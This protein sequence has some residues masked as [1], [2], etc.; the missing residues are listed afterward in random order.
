MRR[1][2]GAAKP[3]APPPALSD[4]IAS[5]DSRA[6]SIDKKIAR[7]DAELRKYKD[8]M[9]KMREGPAKNAVKQKALRVLKQKKM[10]ENQSDNLR[11]QS[12]NMEQANFATETLKDT[13]ATVAAMKVGV[14]TM[15][16]E[17]KKIN[18]DQIDD[19]Q[20][21]LAD[22]LQ[23]A[24]EIQ[25][26]LG[27]SYA[28][29]DIDESE[30]E[31]EL[32]ALGDEIGLDA[33]SSYLDEIAAPNAPSREPG[34]ESVNAA[35]FGFQLALTMIMASFLQKLGVYYS[36]GRWLLCSTG[37]TRFL[38]PTDVELKT[39]MKAQT[40]E[41]SRRRHKEKEGEVKSS[42][43]V[44][45]N[46]DIPLETAKV[47]ST[48]VGQ[49]KFYTEY[50]W[51]LDFSLFSIF[52]YA[53]SEWYYYYFESSSTEINLSLL[54]CLLV[55]GFTLKILWSVTK[56]YFLGDE[57]MGER[58]MCIVA[59]CAYLVVAMAL[60]V[61]DEDTLE[62]GLDAA[63]ASF[64]VRAAV[65]M[66]ER[67]IE[68]DG[69]ASKL[70]LKFALA[71]KAAILGAFLTFPGFRLAQ[72]HWDALRKY[73][74]SSEEDSGIT[75]ARKV[76]FVGLLH[77]NYIAPLVV[78][79]AWVRP[80][81]RDYFTL[82]V[83]SGMS[84]PLMSEAA[85]ETGRLWLIVAV[86]LLR[87]VLMPFYLQAY[88]NLAYKRIAKQKKEAGKISN[89]D[90]QRGVA[91]VFYYLCV[92]TLQ[93]AAPMI[94]C[95]FQLF[96]LKSAG[97][98]SWSISDEL[99]CPADD[100]MAKAAF[101]SDEM[102]A[103]ESTF[104][105]LTKQMSLTLSSVR[106]VFSETVIR[107]V[108]S[109]TLWWTGF[110]WF[111]SSA[112]GEIRTKQGDDRQ[113]PIGFVLFMP[114]S[115][116]QEAYP[117]KIR[118]IMIEKNSENEWSFRAMSELENDLQQQ[119]EDLTRTSDR[120]VTAALSWLNFVIEDPE[121][122]DVLL[123]E[124]D[125]DEVTSGNLKLET[126]ADPAEVPLIH[127]ESSASEDGL[128]S[129]SEEESSIV[130]RHDGANPTN[131]ILNCDVEIFDSQLCN[132]MDSVPSI[133]SVTN[134]FPEDVF[135]SNAPV[136]N[137]SDEL[138]SVLGEVDVEQSSDECSA[139][140]EDDTLHEDMSLPSPS[141]V[142]ESSDAPFEN[143]DVPVPFEDLT[144]HSI[145]IFEGAGIIHNKSILKRS[146]SFWLKHSLNRCHVEL[147]D[148]MSLGRRFWSRGERFKRSKSNPSK[149][150]IV[151]AREEGRA[152]LDYEFKHRRNSRQ[153]RVTFNLN[154]GVKFIEKFGQKK[155]RDYHGH[156]MSDHRTGKPRTSSA[157]DRFSKRVEEDRG[158]RTRA[159]ARNEQFSAENP[160]RLCSAAP[161]TESFPR[162]IARRQLPNPFRNR[163]R[164][165]RPSPNECRKQ[166][167]H[168]L[169]S[170]RVSACSSKWRIK[171]GLSE[172]GAP[173][174]A[175]PLMETLSIIANVIMK[176]AA[177]GS[178]QGMPM[179]RRVPQ[180]FSDGIH[181]TSKAVKSPA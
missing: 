143:S 149:Y 138:D 146:S 42:F 76:L 124:D 81:A 30:L 174:D 99:E 85:F 63:Y 31:A 135:V 154:I 90:I 82:R 41:K 106:A 159:A 142:G 177:Q 43:M 134:S 101:L 36:F 157:L 2:F 100:I 120:Y 161:S 145:P 167:E 72:M 56:L 111:S 172:T 150:E 51:L 59:G 173:P 162:I 168:S 17:F 151:D 15:Q 116:E 4:C 122:L 40:H 121:F 75:R 109:F 123:T 10:Y 156:Q 136:S 80:L 83:W 20:D 169:E 89:K 125:A 67:G 64:K 132:G 92:V 49:L 60:L 108:L 19:L 25:E 147:V 23:D 171:K 13:Q 1:M 103:A 9:A 178:D 114:D 46:L 48:D 163:H 130:S 44:P 97:G 69:P 22:M 73:G 61:V 77:V 39:L 119:L 141:E 128:T 164:F 70:I 29:P 133:S 144:C 153:S 65:F 57:A 170:R 127:E 16:K 3:K 148:V 96:I 152:I 104:P 176:D 158:K 87:L 112:I 66:Q 7:L 28:T 129:L 118:K 58:S 105:N 117:D 180:T 55:L 62:L 21:E 137:E 12:F 98:Y 8:Q 88:L 11:A 110:T 14:K 107:G 34:A 166:Q 18:I 94:L 71:T 140:V 86:L 179:N 54:W 5:V 24:D 38:Y 160:F 175:E 26:T 37:L 113:R 115:F 32:D 35:L 33:D 45:R 126:E 47:S 74:S 139:S 131:V 27:R 52:V 78:V 50:Q 155:C 68:H 84:G 181:E 102:G 53:I 91:R 95:L 6:E 93:Y 79:L 165:M